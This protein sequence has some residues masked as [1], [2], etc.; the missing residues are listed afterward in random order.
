MIQT[1]DTEYETILCYG[2]VQ[3]FH[4]SALSKIFFFFF[5]EYWQKDV[6]HTVHR[7]PGR[8]E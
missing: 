3:E 8:T 5:S 2:A 6:M 1:I 4:E 7:K